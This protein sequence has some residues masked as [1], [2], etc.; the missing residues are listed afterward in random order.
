LSLQIRIPK[1]A[2]RNLIADGRPAPAHIK[3]GAKWV[4]VRKRRDQTKSNSMMKAN[5]KTWPATPVEASL[6][7]TEFAL[8]SGTA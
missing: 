3:L 1:A 2:I 5:L 8:L 4:E 6:E 7:I